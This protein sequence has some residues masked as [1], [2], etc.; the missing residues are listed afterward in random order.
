MYCCTAKP[1]AGSQIAGV[2]CREG[3]GPLTDLADTGRSIFVTSRLNTILTVAASALGL[4][5][6]FIRLL[7][8]GYAGVSFTLMMLLLLSLPV[9]VLG[10]FTNTV[11]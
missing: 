3:L 7:A 8:S 6:S 9:L 5:I 4:L 1:A 2:V 10:I 11:N